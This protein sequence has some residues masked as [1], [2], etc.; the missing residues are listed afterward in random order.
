MCL[1]AEDLQLGASFADAGSIPS[2]TLG[3][4][5]PVLLESVPETLSLKLCNCLNCP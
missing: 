5:C 3:S 1:C 4:L 2:D